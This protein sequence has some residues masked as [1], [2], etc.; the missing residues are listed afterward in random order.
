MSKV[1]VGI[2]QTKC[3]I[4]ANS[5]FERLK[6]YM[7]DKNKRL[8]IKAG[9]SGVKILSLQELFFGPYFPAEQNIKWYDY[10]ETIPGPTTEEFAPLAKKYEMALILPIMEETISGLYYNTAVIIGTK[11]EIIGKFRK[12]HLPHCFP[13]FWEKFYF[14]NGDLGFPV[15]N[16]PY[17][18][19]GVYLCYDRH[20]PECARALGLAGAEIVF[21][22]S[23]TVAGLSESLW[24]LEQP[25]QAVANGIFV[26]A[27]NRVG[28]EEPWNIGEFYGTSYIC[29]PKGQIIAE[30][31]RDKD[32]LLSTEI[33]LNIILEV[34]KIWQFYRDR[35]PEVYKSF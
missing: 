10:A 33:D 30:A 27:I 13:G 6:T 35:R 11:G 31:P 18:K 2:I 28:W 1:S 20:F 4:D 7:W 34:R 12:V 32:F 16:T 19:I 15:F 21:N 17:A 24:K 25:A 23:A 5:P 9:E 8:V 3:D 22:P 29:D 14:R 26:S